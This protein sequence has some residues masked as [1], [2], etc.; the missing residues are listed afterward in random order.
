MFILY[1]KKK[2]KWLII[3]DRVRNS[4]SHSGPKNVLRTWTCSVLPLATALAKAHRSQYV[5]HAQNGAP[6]LQACPLRSPGHMPGRH[7]RF[8]LDTTC[9]YSDVDTF[10]FQ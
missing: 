4:L 6:F 3:V 5:V 1:F 8:N 10:Y 9:T 2:E 7:V